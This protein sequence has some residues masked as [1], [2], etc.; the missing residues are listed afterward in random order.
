MK[1]NIHYSK[2]GQR[3]L[4][5]FFAKELIF[6]HMVDQL[7]KDRES[8]FQENFNNNLEVQ[9]EKK[10]IQKAIQYCNELSHVT[11]TEQ[12]NEYLLNKESYLENILKKIQ[13]NDWP[14]GVKAGLETLLVVCVLVLVLIGTPWDKIAKKN[15]ISSSPILITE[16]SRTNNSE[17]A[18]ASANLKEVPSEQLYKDEVP[19]EIL[20]EKKIHIEPDSKKPI[21]ISGKQNTQTGQSPVKPEVITKSESEL[22]AQTE[23]KISGG[24]LY[25]GQLSVANLKMT[26]LK[27]NAEIG[28]MGGR[29]AGEVE[30]GWSKTQKQAYYHFT[31]PE[32]KYDELITFLSGFG[33][34]QL[35]KER[36][37]RIMPDGIVRI[38][39]VVDEKNK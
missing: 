29:K 3:E 9:G 24:F 5:E 4:S 10:K 39:I 8:S 18:V 19:G 30:L 27:L 35:K 20:K 13:F 7:D 25:R 6:D 37:P 17:Q 36:H 22:S 38:I 21:D 34:P 23:N 28:I 16:L 26:R 12:L 11:I 14:V 2:K 32:T 33:K 1:K 31:I 15:F